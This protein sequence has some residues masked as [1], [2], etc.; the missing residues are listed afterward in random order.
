[1]DFFLD[2]RDHLRFNRVRIIFTFKNLKMIC[3]FVAKK[4]RHIP[5]SM[6]RFVD[7]D[8]EY[9]I[10]FWPNR[11]HGPHRVVKKSKVGMPARKAEIYMIFK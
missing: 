6:T 8:H 9:I 4:P 5:S 1:M 10:R 3:V 2:G 11:A 7:L